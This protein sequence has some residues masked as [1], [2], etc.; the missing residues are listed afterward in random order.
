MAS[1][2][3]AVERLRSRNRGRDWYDLRLCLNSRD[4]AV[5][6]LE[7]AISGFTVT[8]TPDSMRLVKV[9]WVRIPATHFIDPTRELPEGDSRL[10]PA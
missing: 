8:L 6:C 10:F 1:A 7:L 2:A 5:I 3:A 9:G 4:R